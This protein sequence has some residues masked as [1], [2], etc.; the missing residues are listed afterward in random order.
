MGTA[1]GRYTHV[2]KT[3]ERKLSIDGLSG[4]QPFKEGQRYYA[5]IEAVAEG[6]AMPAR[7][8]EIRLDILDANHISAQTKIPWDF[9]LK[10][11][12]ANFTRMIL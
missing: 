2:F 4:N 5:V 8:E 6:V 1:P 11:I 12:W 7:T 10:V 3:R 9:P